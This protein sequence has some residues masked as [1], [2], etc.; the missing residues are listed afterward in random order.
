MVGSP[1]QVVK[2]LWEYIKSNELQ[3]PGN[4]QSILPDEKMLTL[5]S[6]PLTMFT[7]NKQLSRHILPK[8]DPPPDPPPPPRPPGNTCIW[9]PA[10]SSTDAI[11]CL[12]TET[13]AIK[14]Q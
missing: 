9:L 5:F 10:Q 12:V 14:H 11:R 2:R 8:G 13:V 1:V 3:D 7:M 6:A 4:K